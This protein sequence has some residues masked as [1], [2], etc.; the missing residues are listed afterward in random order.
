MIQAISYATAKKCDARH[1]S[2][3]LLIVSTLLPGLL[4]GQ[5]CFSRE[6]PE[7]LRFIADGYE[8][9][10]KKLRTWR[11]TAI[12]RVGR[13]SSQSSKGDM[14]LNFDEETVEQLKFVAD[15]DRDAASWRG[16]PVIQK[17]PNS[18]PQRQSV[19]VNSGMNNGKYHYRMDVMREPEKHQGHER[20]L[21]VYGK[22]AVPHGIQLEEF[23]PVWVLIE[24]IG[25]HGTMGEALRNWAQ[26]IEDEMPIP[27]GHGYNVERKGDVVAIKFYGPDDTEE[28]GTSYSSYVFDI[29]KGCSMVGQHHVSSQSETHWEL[30]YEKRNDVFVAKQ[31]SRVRR[32]KDGVLRQHVAFKTMTVNKPVSESEFSY[33]AL[34]L[35][36][37]D[38]IVDHTKGGKR[39]IW[40]GN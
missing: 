38:H 7:L 8:A 37:G 19:R 13:S 31:I 12:R 28:G 32:D 9:N 21:L 25:A 22:N 16:V 34:G 35:R 33:E 6:D 3:R 39:S 27:E 2:W 24:D 23:D 15:R 20:I 18:E 4:G 1:L 14:R 40:G 30:D 36:P 29:S 17:D 5:K 26:G 11:G 10:L